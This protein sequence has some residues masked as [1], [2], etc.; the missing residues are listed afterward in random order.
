LRSNFLISKSDRIKS[1]ELEKNSILCL[2]FVFVFGGV[3]GF[4]KEV[5]STTVTEN[6]IG[7]ARTGNT[8]YYKDAENNTYRK[9]SV[10][11]SGGFSGVT[12]DDSPQYEKEIL[13]VVGALLIEK[14]LIHLDKNRIKN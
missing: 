12:F 9:T 3:F 13:M 6:A 1:N 8:T 10:A 4:I 11:R 14:C 2:S 5:F 7:G